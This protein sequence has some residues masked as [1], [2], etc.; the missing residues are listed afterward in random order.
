M[1]YNF[2]IKFNASNENETFEPLEKLYT[3]YQ[4]SLGSSSDVLSFS[5]WMAAAAEAAATSFSV[6][7][8]KLLLNAV[9]FSNITHYVPLHYCIFLLYYLH[10]RWDRPL[11]CPQIVRVSSPLTWWASPRRWWARPPGPRRG[12]SRR[13]PRQKSCIISMIH[14]SFANN[15]SQTFRLRNWEAQ[16]RTQSNFSSQQLL[17]SPSSIN[18]K[19]TGSTEKFSWKPVKCTMTLTMITIHDHV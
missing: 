15:L 5:F 7:G 14:H 17:M 9:V 8:S 13:H 11:F 2:Q 12:C 1:L 4:Q 19:A 18:C 16:A 6:W 10:N 3:F